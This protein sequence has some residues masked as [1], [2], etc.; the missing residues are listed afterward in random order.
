MPV[1]GDSSAS[2]ALLSEDSFVI[3]NF[4]HD[5]EARKHLP[6]SSYGSL[7]VYQLSA[8]DTNASSKP[9]CVASFAMPLLQYGRTETIVRI[10]STP[11]RVAAKPKAKV[12]DLAPGNRLLFLDVRVRSASL[13]SQNDLSN[14]TLC[15]PSSL[16]LNVLPNGQQSRSDVSHHIVVPWADWAEKT[17]WVNTDGFR[18]GNE[19]GSSI[20]K[21]LWV[22]GQRMAG[23]KENQREQIFVLDFD[24]HRSKPVNM[25]DILAEGEVHSLGER[26]S[27]S[28]DVVGETFCSGDTRAKGRYVEMSI[29][30]GKHLTPPYLVAVDDE[31]REC[32]T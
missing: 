22:S 27:T 8:D 24:Q 28:L 6:D 5:P 14:G 15:V 16:L 21:G 25:P 3:P 19:G 11:I 9:I 29:P 31:Y 12:F 4:S 30:L 1:I 20:R 17:C 32:M 10:R 23:F 18:D 7:D 26:S 2:F 13:T